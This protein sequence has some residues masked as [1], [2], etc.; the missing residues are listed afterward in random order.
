MKKIVIAADLGASGGKMAKGYFDGSILKVDDFYDFPNEPM[1]LNGNLY[2][3][4][5]GL[6]NSIRNGISYYAKDS[7]VESVAVD[8]WGASYGFLDEK[9]RLLEPIYHYR[10]LRTEYTMKRMYEILP[11]RQLFEMTGCQPARSYTLPQLYSYVER[12]ERI[13]DLADKM[14]FLPDLLEYFLSGEIATERS[15]AGTSG[16]LRPDQ[17]DWAYEVFDIFGIQKRMLTPISDAGIQ[18]GSLLRN[19]GQSTGA[20]NAKVIASVGHDTA[21]SVAGIPGFGVGQVYISIGTNINMGI[22]LTENVTSEKAYRGGYKNAAVMEDRNILYRDFSAFWLL[23]ELR[24]TWKEEG[25]EY[26]YQVIMD[27]AQSRESKGIYVDVDDVSLNNA[28]GN[29]KEKIN[30]YLQKTGQPRLQ[31]EGD[32]VRC[33]LESIA[34]KVKYCTEYFTKELHIPLHRVSVINGGT[35]NYV[36]MQMFSDA[37]GMPVYCGLP[38]ATLV[39]NVLTQM[40]ALGEVRTVDEMREL[41]DRSFRMKEYLPGTDTKE[42]WDAD[43]WK[44]TEKGICK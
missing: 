25:K 14:L 27:M 18:R 36:L 30:A 33:I 9:G 26:S 29:T 41:S 16:L 5:F 34:L 20:G 2:W 4:L 37:L 3:D 7:E 24:R 39:G 31:E 6:Y 15:I 1:D 10:D 38:Y 23:N 42:R 17:Q 13:I 19:V 35:R 32:F 8:S 21:S 11:K 44:M 12:H 43:L 40:Y 22:E 28:G